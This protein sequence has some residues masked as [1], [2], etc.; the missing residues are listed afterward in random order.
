MK[1]VQIMSFGAPDVL[2]VNDVNRP[3]PG[4]GEVLVVRAGGLRIVSGCRFPIGVGLDF[5]GVVVATGATVDDFDREGVRPL[6]GQ[7][8]GRRLLV[9]RAQQVSHHPHGRDDIGDRNDPL[10]E[11]PVDGLAG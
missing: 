2:R 1:A 9:A 6:C 3:T 10:V 11:V 4:A 7:Q 5:A 8:H